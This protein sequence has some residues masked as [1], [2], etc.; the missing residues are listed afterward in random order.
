TLPIGV[1]QITPVH[2]GERER[3]AASDRLHRPREVLPEHRRA[4]Y[5]MALH[6]LLPRALEAG[7]IV[8][9]GAADNLRHV[10]ARLGL[11]E[12]VE[13]HALLRGRQRI[14]V[15]DVLLAAHS[16]STWDNT[17]SSCASSSAANGKSDGVYAPTPGVVQ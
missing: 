14:D 1:A 4:Q 10:R 2:R 15:F 9:H 8:D 6:H 17:S 13:E 3:H 16:N 12:R 11:V 5:R 7:G